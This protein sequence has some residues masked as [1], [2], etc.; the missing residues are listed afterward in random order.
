MS[1]EWY[2]DVINSMDEG[3]CVI[4]V[5]Y[6]DAGKPVDWRYLKINPKYIDQGGSAEDVGQLASVRYPHTDRLWFDFYGKVAASGI[7]ARMEGR[8]KAD[9]KWYSIYAAKIGG[10]ESRK[11]VALFL[12]ITERKNAEDTLRKSEKRARELV[13]ELEEADKNTN[14]FISVMSHELRNPLAVIVACM[15]L[16][17]ISTKPEQTEKAKE[18]IRRQ[19]DHLT[20]LV[21]DLLDIT[22]IRQNK[23]QLNMQIVD[24]CDIMKNAAEDMHQEFIAKGTRLYTELPQ[25]P[26]FLRADPVRINQCASNLLRNA[27]NYTQR[28]GEVAMSL[29]IEEGEAI[30]RVR[31][32]GLGI[33][34]ELLEHIFK[35]FTNA[36][37]SLN[38]PDYGGLGLGLSI[39]HAI[40]RLHGGSVSAY[41][42]GTGKGSLFTIRLPIP[43]GV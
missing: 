43:L 22:R 9:D 18:S 20:T 7:S 17:E 28:G 6:D 36:C 38:R 30:I 39:V 1:E 13:E 10:Q 41:S 35:P 34:S 8:L 29:V 37:M 25:S 27:L 15:S 23:V 42:Q 12:D 5:I 19:V 16:L 2:R 11:V 4:D 21:D 26:V 32:N 14:R 3:F 31:D 33:D 24:L 40:V